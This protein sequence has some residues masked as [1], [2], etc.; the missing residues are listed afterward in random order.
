MAHQSLYRRYR[1]RRFGEVRGQQHLVDALR[2][3]VIE[4]RVGHAYLFSG[5]RGTGK[6]STARILAKVL[7]CEAPID[8]EPCCECA[9]CLSVESGTSFDVHELDAASNNG[10][11]NIR[12]LIS[13]AALGTPGRTKVYI[14]DEVHMLTAAA[15]NALLKILEEPPDHVVFVLATTDPQKVLPT[16]RSRAQHFE[17]TLLPA[18]DL[19][20]LVDF[21]VADAE[22]ELSAA[23]RAHVLRVGGGSARDTLSALDRVVAAGGVPD[24]DGDAV[25]ELVEALCGRDTARAL[26]AVE[27]ALARGRSPRVLGEALIARLRDV[28]LAAVGAPL[29]RLTEADRTRATDQAGRLGAVGATRALEVLGDAFVGIQD[30]LDPRIPL[31]I[32]LVRL[33]RADADISVAALAD[34]L[35][36]LE[37]GGPSRGAPEGPAPRG[38]AAAA[39][40]PRTEPMADAGAEPPAEPVVDAAPAAAPAAAADRGVSTD[41]PEDLP[42]PPIPAG[43]SPADG[44]R[45]MLRQRSGSAR[46]AARPAASA[47]PSRPATRPAPP[48]PAG[49][50]QPAPETPATGAS[51]PESAGEAAPTPPPSPTPAAPAVAPVGG[52]TPPDLATLTERWSTSVLPS[53]SQRARPRFTAGRWLAI[54][55]TEAVLGLPNAPHAARCEE[56]R[57]EVEAA[58]SAAFGTPLT[59]RLAVD[60]AAVDPGDRR[61]MAGRRAEPVEEEILDSQTIAELDDA[62]DVA[63]S[64]VDRVAAMFP[65]AE[66]VDDPEP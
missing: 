44:A 38:A 53:L 63:A 26:I 5:P 19:E 47:A 3:A 27:N 41:D 15:S 30:A 43:G 42:I 46:P 37:Q 55:G 22:L 12:D 39:A 14:L 24:D 31:E 28:F 65:G 52:G 1:P 7:N 8:G 64:G 62:V 23:G 36:R 40:R 48:R 66:L 57:P 25:D 21:V 59:L 60:G 32:A 56:L 10:V 9:S 20:A 2:N 11:D 61:A 34:R 13:R 50:R 51:A 18:A 45:E 17:V 33:T 16:I 35:A 4:D 6:T 54:E 29:P 58:L 49:R